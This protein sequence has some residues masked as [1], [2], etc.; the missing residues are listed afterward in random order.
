MNKDIK[1]VKNF[2]ICATNMTWGW[3][4]FK[5]IRSIFEPSASY[6]IIPNVSNHFS[7]DLKETLEKLL[8]FSE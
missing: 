3:N 1:G 6:Q 5:Q 2:R 4:S 7:G 8:P